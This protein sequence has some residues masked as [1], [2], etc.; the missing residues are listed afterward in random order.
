MKGSAGDYGKPKGG[1]ALAAAA[2]RFSDQVL[3]G[4]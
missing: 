3:S 4:D 2:V 1:L